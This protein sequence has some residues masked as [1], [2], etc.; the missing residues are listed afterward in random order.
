Q[1]SI[2]LSAEEGRGAASQ[3]PP[4]KLPELRQRASIPMKA[5]PVRDRQKMRGHRVNE[6]AAGAADD[7]RPGTWIDPGQEN[8]QRHCNQR[9]SQLEPVDPSQAQGA[10]QRENGGRVQ[11]IDDELEGPEAD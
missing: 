10:S 6:R 7:Q 11:P 3:N 8:G 5:I 2:A 1:N 4:T 9:L